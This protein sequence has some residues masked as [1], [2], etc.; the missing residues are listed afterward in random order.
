M[1][2]YGLIS[3][4]ADVKSEKLAT[5]TKDEFAKNLQVALTGVIFRVTE[6]MKVFQGGGWEIMSHQLNSLGSFL[7]VSFLIRRQK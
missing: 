4:V 5:A 7:V 3:E 1:Y 2:E 6:R